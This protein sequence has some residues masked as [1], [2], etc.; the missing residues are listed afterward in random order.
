MA[1]FVLKHASIT[2]NGIDLTDHCNAVEVNQ[3]FDEVDLTGFCSTFRTMG[4]GAGDAT[5]TATFLSDFA[6]AS[7]DATLWPLSQGGG[8]FDVVVRSV[9]TIAVSATNP[10]YTMTS[11]LF[12]YAPIAGAYGDAST[13]DV[14]FRNA[15]TAGLVRG[16]T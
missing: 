2:V 10:K 13:T 8:T 3:E 16:T 1:T 5:I 9:G 14:T 15:G 7:V 12:S 6:A 11:R 4:V